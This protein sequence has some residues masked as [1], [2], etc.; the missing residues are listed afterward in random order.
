MQIDSINI[1]FKSNG[2]EKSDI[3]TIISMV[4]KTNNPPLYRIIR[5]VRFNV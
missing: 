1:Y 4:V 2:T 3:N 5:L